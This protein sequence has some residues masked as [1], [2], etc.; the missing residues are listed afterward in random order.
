MLLGAAPGVG[1]TYTM[2]E[3]GRR[4][5]DEGK[6][7]VVAVVETHGRAATASVL[8]DLEV[9]PRR[10]VEHR[11]VELDE[12][13]LE[14]VLARRPQLALVDELAHTNAPGGTHDKR[15]RDVQV[16]L[17]AG[18]SVIST[19]NVQH[20]E[21][22]NDVVEQITGTV[23]R[24]TVPDAVLR[25]ADQLEVVDLAPQA[26]RDRLAAGD[27][28]PASRVDAA[29]SNYFRLGNLTALRELALLWLADR[30]DEG[31]ERYRAQQGIERS[32]PARERVV[33]ALTGG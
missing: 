23:Q 22:L 11:G 28:Y 17:D 2:L 13:D 30:V 19:V 6:D 32:W 25:S 14:G 12:M 4:L 8:G 3:E 29:L 7:V 16:L 26:L 20:I 33:V 5:R 27:V 9:V 31:L 18:I 10:V 21:S 1:K 15:W 24:E